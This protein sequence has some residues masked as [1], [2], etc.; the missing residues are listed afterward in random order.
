MAIMEI[1]VVPIGVGSSV[2]NYVA[3]CVEVIKRS[4]LSY[5]VTAMGTIVEGEVD[6]L[7]ELAS[8]VHKV[9]F[10][11]GA[12]RVLTNIKIDERVDKKS[13]IKSKVLSVKDKVD[14]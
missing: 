4:G 11:M 3:K 7:L 8:I 14:R 12:K 6:K 2:S 13:T 10:E 9:P 1:S 5:E